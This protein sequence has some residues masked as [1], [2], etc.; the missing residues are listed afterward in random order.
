MIPKNNMPQE[1]IEYRK[2]ENIYIFQDR[3]SNEDIKIDK[4]SKVRCCC[5]EIKIDLSTHSLIRFPDENY[6]K[7]Q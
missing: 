1:S 7:D 5:F 4:D 3:S 2:N 6:G